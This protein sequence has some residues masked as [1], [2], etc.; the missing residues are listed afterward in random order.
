MKILAI[1]DDT[2]MTDLLRLTLETKLEIITT[3]SSLDA[4]QKVKEQ[5]PDLILLD[6]MMND[7]DGWEVCKLIREFSKIPILILSALDSPGL[8]ATALDAGAD[9]YLIKPVASGVLLAHIHK[10][11]RRGQ[12]FP[13]IAVSPI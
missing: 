9:D 4:D 11:A 8:V 13:T 7:M 1:D 12:S 2:A 3:N 10:L 5:S 6:L